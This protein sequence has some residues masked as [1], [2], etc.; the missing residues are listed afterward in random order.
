MSSCDHDKCLTNNGEESRFPVSILIENQLPNWVIQDHPKFIAFLEAYYEWLQL[1][2]NH[3]AAKYC[4]KNNLDIDNTID[5]FIKFF[6]KEYL[7]NIPENLYSKSGCNEIE[8]PA[9]DDEFS[10][11]FDLATNENSEIKVY[12]DGILANP[13]K[14]TISQDCGDSSRILFDSTEYGDEFDFTESDPVPIIKIEVCENVE[15]NVR[16]LI[17]TIKEM[18]ASKGTEASYRLLFKLLYNEEID[19]IY[20]NE[21][22]LKPSN[23]KWVKTPTNVTKTK[24]FQIQNTTVGTFSVSLAENE[25]SF[26]KKNNVIVPHTYSNGKISINSVTNGDTVDVYSVGSPVP[27]YT[28]NVFPV[29]D[30]TKKTY[31]LG[32]NIT[33]APTQSQVKLMHTKGALTFEIE[34]DH[35]K[36]IEIVNNGQIETAFV[37]VEYSDITVG[38]IFTLKIENGLLGNTSPTIWES[39]VAQQKPILKYGLG[40]TFNLANT[41][42]TMAVNGNTW[43]QN[44]P[45]EEFSGVSGSII[46]LTNDISGLDVSLIS[47]Y[48]NGELLENV[49]DYT[50]SYNISPIKDEVSFLSPL[51]S[52]D[53]VEVIISPPYELYDDSGIFIKFD[54]ACGFSGGENV[55]FSYQPKSIQGYFKNEDGKL[56]SIDVLQ[57]SYKYQQFSYIIKTAHTTD[58][59]GEY[60]K[61]LLHP[62]GMAMFGEI[63][64]TQCISWMI[65]SYKYYV[66][67]KSHDVEST[68]SDT[69]ALGPRWYSFEINKF[70]YGLESQGMNNTPIEVFSDEIIGD[71]IDMPDKGID[72]LMDSK[73]IVTI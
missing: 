24:N 31:S 29:T 2:G 33:P 1:D 37:L 63:L 7:F 12:V 30:I 6:K 39:F 59:Y 47:V 5:E 46:Q 14:Y 68:N 28:D 48:K 11:K 57:D 32:T 69:N 52:T 20:P 50:F 70:A 49:T 3:Y 18:N 26:V 22:L 34:H 4:L 42:T 35:Y 19:I 51:V 15:V 36:I 41:I 8:F 21:Q 43:K 66:D 25:I 61:T 13:E 62:S 9:K 53:T 27:I 72:L 38:D 40:T 55:V 54:S 10:Y 23:G 60:L 64:L 17:K 71:A 58:E 44:Y 45:I 16:L 67:I 56:S 73:I 65:S